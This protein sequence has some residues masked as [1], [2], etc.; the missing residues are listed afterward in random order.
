VKSKFWRVA[1]RGEIFKGRNMVFGPID[2]PL[3]E[4]FKL[5][6]K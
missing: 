4:K 6:D 2:R 5:G 1:R 3:K